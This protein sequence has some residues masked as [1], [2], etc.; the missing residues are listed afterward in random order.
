MV[1]RRILAPIDGSEHAERA[2]DYALEL[3]GQLGAEVEI[4]IVVPETVETPE[5]MREYTLKMKEEG[6]RT[7]SKAAEGAREAHP[8]VTVTKEL[9]EGYAT[10]KILEA[11]NKGGFDMIVM[12][13][14]GL[15][16]VR[17]LL[18]GSV[19]SKV[20]NQAEIPVLIVK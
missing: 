4:L 18:L 8:D 13:N 14:R 3:A 2:L 1:V 12:G 5:W 16:L 20:V 10:E 11:A 19:S 6:E 15:G 17:G 7:I 9:E